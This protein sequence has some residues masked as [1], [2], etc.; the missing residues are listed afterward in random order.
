MQQWGEKSQEKE[1]WEVKKQTKSETHA[2]K[3]TENESVGN[4]LPVIQSTLCEL[5]IK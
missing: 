3:N 2:K 1:R 5:F 4:A